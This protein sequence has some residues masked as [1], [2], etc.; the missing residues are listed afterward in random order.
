M[1]LIWKTALIF[2]SQ[3]LS[4]WDLFINMEMPVCSMLAGTA[5]SFL[6]RFFSFLIGEYFPRR[7]LI[8]PFVTIKI[9]N[10]N[11]FIFYLVMETQGINI[12]TQVLIEASN[13]LKV[14]YSFSI[15]AHE[16]H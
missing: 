16:C 12:N 9:I 4:L 11:L 13:T 1:S 10:L 3:A 8:S 2:F 15:V 5:N 7:H 6:F 14:N